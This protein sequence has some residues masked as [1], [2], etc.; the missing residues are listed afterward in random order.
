MENLNFKEIPRFDY[1]N[2]GISFAYI[3]LL[4]TLYPLKSMVFHT[5]YNIII[6]YCK[7]IKLFVFYNFS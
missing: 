2:L 5:L 1:I 3:S 4:Q 6:D 7:I